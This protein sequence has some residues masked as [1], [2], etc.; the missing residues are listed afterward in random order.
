MIYL[1]KILPLLASPLFLVIFLILSGLIINSRKFI[2]MALFTLLGYSFP[3]ISGYLISSLE[4]NYKLQDV[5][6][7]PTADA[8]VLF[9][10]FIVPV[11]TDIDYSC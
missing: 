3:P 6:L 10:G 5:Q 4:K 7:I 9:S 2:L 8:I 11:K 1:H